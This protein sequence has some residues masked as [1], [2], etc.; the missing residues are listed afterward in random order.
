MDVARYL[1]KKDLGTKGK[2]KIG[3]VQIS[4]VHSI[5]ESMKAWE[6]FDTMYKYEVNALAVVT[7]D[8]TLVTAISTT[9]LKSIN[10][11]HIGNIML[12]VIKFLNFSLGEKPPVPITCKTLDHIEDVLPKM[13]IAKVHQVWMT[14]SAEH[15]DGVVTMTDIIKL[16]VGPPT[17]NTQKGGNETP[18]DSIPAK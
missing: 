17:V 8:D 9:D 11:E 6:A 14:D 16:L 4:K 2:Q 3:E 18:I 10:E 1:V 15:P 5:N 7:E 13:V 12:R